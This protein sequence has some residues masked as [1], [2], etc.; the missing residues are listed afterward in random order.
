MGFSAALGSLG[1]FLCR[2]RSEACL[3]WPQCC[4]SLL[5]DDNGVARQVLLGSAHRD[6]SVS[7]SRT[8]A[9][10][11]H[12]TPSWPKERLAPVQHSPSAS[13]TQSQN[14]L[15]SLIACF[16]EWGISNGY[17]TKNESSTITTMPEQ[18]SSTCCRECLLREGLGVS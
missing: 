18:S 16:A 17:S 1:C 10:R 4:P 3:C 6:H 15:E 13:H 9:A 2:V 5:S 11:A 12:H 14:R 7:L 8:L